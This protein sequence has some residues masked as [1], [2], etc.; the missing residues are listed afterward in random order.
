MQLNIVS[1][2]G[3][4]IA[5][6]S[7][8]LDFN[9]ENTDYV[10]PFVKYSAAKAVICSLGKIQNFDFTFDHSGFNGIKIFIPDYKISTS[11]DI[12]KTTEV[13]NMF[14]SGDVLLHIIIDQP[15]TTEE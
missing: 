3:I 13:L 9:V 15:S 6:T 10:I 8:R 7:I 11:F 14:L 1:Y 5:N 4:I 2:D 12:E